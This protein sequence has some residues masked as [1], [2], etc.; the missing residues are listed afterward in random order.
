[1]FRG[2][3]VSMESARRYIQ[4]ARALLIMQNVNGALHESGLRITAHVA[5]MVIFLLEAVHP[6]RP[7]ISGR[8]F[9]FA[10]KHIG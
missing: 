7:V 9:V 10:S 6:H 3:W 8:G 4:T 2:R 1:M 5:T